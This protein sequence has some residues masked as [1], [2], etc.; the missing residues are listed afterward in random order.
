MSLWHTA[1]IDNSSDVANRC[2]SDISRS[3]TNVTTRLPRTVSGGA[4]GRP[5]FGFSPKFV[6]TTDLTINIAD[7][8]N[9]PN[10]GAISEIGQIIRIRNRTMQD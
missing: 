9:S 2:R 3:V 10:P 4:G 7:K 6:I 1:D 8:P 5:G